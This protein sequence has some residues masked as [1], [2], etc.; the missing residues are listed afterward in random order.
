MQHGTI[1][2]TEELGFGSEELNRSNTVV[3]EQGLMAH[4]LQLG[5]RH[6]LNF[7]QDT[8]SAQHLKQ[9]RGHEGGSRPGADQALYRA[10]VSVSILVPG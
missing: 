3:Q 7:T 9:S 8:K 10:T 5:H 1:G 4:L 2:C 6:V